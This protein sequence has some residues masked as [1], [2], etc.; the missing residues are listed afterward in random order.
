LGAG[1]G[2]ENLALAYQQGE[3]VPADATKGWELHER[4]C[5]S[6][7][8][9]SCMKL[10]ERYAAGQGTT[11]RDLSRARSFLQHACEEG[12]T[13]ACQMNSTVQSCQTHDP[14]ACKMLDDLKARLDGAKPPDASSDGG[15]SP[16]PTPAPS[17]AP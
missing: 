16:A 10:G 14:E 15:A 1:A 13:E 17:S 7:R 4:A 3:G 11:A 12:D 8:G 6:R 5:S 2:C 9:F